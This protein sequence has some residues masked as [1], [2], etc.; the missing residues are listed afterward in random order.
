[1]DEYDMEP[2]K[3]S[4]MPS[5]E[6]PRLVQEAAEQM[7]R[8]RKRLTEQ[9]LHHEELTDFYRNELRTIDEFLSEN[10]LDRPAP[11]PLQQLKRPW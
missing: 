3:E 8:F 11:M 2:S 5:P 9:I 4:P 10:Y 1:M 6:A 7:M